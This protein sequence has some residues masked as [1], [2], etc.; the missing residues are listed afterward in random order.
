MNDQ[1]YVT[2]MCYSPTL[3][4]DLALAFVRRGPARVGDRMQLV[5]HLRDVRTEVEILSPVVF[6]PKGERARG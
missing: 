3:G 6:D 4:H 2:S 5:D 1:G